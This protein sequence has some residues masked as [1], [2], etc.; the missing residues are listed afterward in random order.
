MTISS[1]FVAMMGG[2]IWLES[3]PGRGSIFH[4]TANFGMAPPVQKPTREVPGHVRLTGIGVLVVDDN[5][6]NRRILEHTLLQWGMKPTLVSSGWAA[7][8]EL[9]RAREAGQPT[10]LVL[11]DAQMP[12]LDGFQTASKIKQDPELVAATIMMLT[13]C[14]Q[15]GDADRC[16][17]VGISAYLS[18]PV[19]QAELREA[20]LRVLGSATQQDEP[21]QLVTRHTLKEA[22]RHLR[23]LLADDNAINR[24]LAVRILTKRGHAVSIVPNGK[25]AVEALEAK[26]FDVVLMDLQMPEMDGFEATAAIRRMEQG[27]GTH[28]PIL[29]MTAHAMKSDRERCLTMGMNG[30]ISKPIQAQELIE[31]VESFTGEGGPID[32]ESDSASMVVDWETALGRVGGDEELLS[33]LAKLFLEESS[34][35]LSTVQQ[36]VEGNSASELQR[37]AHSM[38]GSVSTFSAQHAF[39]AALKLERL[40]RAGEMAGVDEAFA[41]LAVEVGRLRT[42][43]ESLSG[44]PKLVR[45]VRNE[46]RS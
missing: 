28:V 25:L 21:S 30:Y 33:D 42:A 29:A 44:V 35:M 32:M 39:D 19:R 12:Q 1:R 14:G 22:R 23:V 17:E 10:P 13:S 5:S 7:L 8:A 9:R 15:R 43:L 24:E 16:R 36:A 20:I 37:A 34:R 27:T 46:S 4:F 26:N 3:E 41:A 6:T 45:G 38:K 40:A 2:R 31:L 18:K 11:L